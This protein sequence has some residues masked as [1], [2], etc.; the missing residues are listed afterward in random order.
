MICLLSSWLLTL[1]LSLPFML[2]ALLTAL[3]LVL[4]MRLNKRTI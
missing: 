2:C 4:F 1:N 3:A